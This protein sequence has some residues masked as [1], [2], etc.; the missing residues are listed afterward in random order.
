MIEANIIARSHFTRWKD[1]ESAYWQF[2]RRV[3]LIDNPIPFSFKGKTGKDGRSTNFVAESWGGYVNAD[4]E[5]VIFVAWRN[6]KL[7][8][9][10]VIHWTWD[11]AQQLA[12]NPREWGFR[13]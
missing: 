2:L 8:E 6:H 3:G 4:N 11:D 12:V 5:W 10:K 7:K 13:S 1:G 9:T